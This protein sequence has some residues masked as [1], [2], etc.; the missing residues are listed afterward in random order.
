MNRLTIDNQEYSINYD[1]GTIAMVYKVVPRVSNGKKIG[2]RFYQVT[3]WEQVDHVLAVN[4]QM[5][6]EFR[7]AHD[8]I[9]SEW[10]DADL[11]ELDD[12]RA[13]QDDASYRS[14]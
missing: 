11:L 10:A 7:A 8:E 12:L 14:Q 1:L 6:A 2:E 9:V 4:A 13:T 5:E 3:D